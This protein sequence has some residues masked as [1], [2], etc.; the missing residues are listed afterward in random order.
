[1]KR[2]TKYACENDNGRARTEEKTLE[3]ERV[4]WWRKSGTET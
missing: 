3:V 2:I 1:M 4:L